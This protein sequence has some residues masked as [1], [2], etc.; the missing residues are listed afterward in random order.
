[1]EKKLDVNVF[2]IPVIYDKIHIYYVNPG[3]ELLK[4]AYR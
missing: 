2:K 4:L 3:K 1:M